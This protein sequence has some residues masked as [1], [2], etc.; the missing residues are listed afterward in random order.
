M[1]A[2]LIRLKPISIGV[3]GTHG[4]TTTCSLI[5][6]ILFYAEKDP[7]LAVGGIVK[8]FNTNAISGKGDISLVEADEYDR[9][10]LSLSPT[11][12]VVNNIELEHLDCYSDIDDLINSF[13]KF[14]NG[15][16]FYGFAMV[17]I[18]DNNIQSII[19]K[20]KRPLI[21]Y[22]IDHKADYHAKNINFNK[23]NTSFDLYVRG[24]MIDTIYIN[25]PG[26]HNIYNTLCAIGLCQ[27]LDIDIEI[28]KNALINFNH[29]LINL[30]F[31][32]IIQIS[33]RYYIIY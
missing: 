21:S 12:C 2:E 22:G 16:P 28:I 13:K 27:E 5:G 14:V 4:K 7:T 33:F 32:F 19:T 8:S 3:S 1:L 17:N 9:S 10:F 11:I 31:D 24:K 18:D 23:N 25:I 6:S 15:I 20:I 29:L 30:Y 26:K